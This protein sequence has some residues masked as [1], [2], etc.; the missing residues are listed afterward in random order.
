MLE[1]KATGCGNLKGE[2]FRP[3]NQLVQRPSDAGKMKR[4]SQVVG[5]KSG[6]RGGM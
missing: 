4:A 2:A 5:M 6:Q 3:W 1:L